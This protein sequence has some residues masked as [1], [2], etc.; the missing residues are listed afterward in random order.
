MTE[1][2]IQNISLYI[3]NFHFWG[4]GAAFLAAFLETILGLGLIFPGSSMILFLGAAAAYG[5]LDFNGVLI[6]SM[7]GAVL[8]DNINYYLGRNYAQKWIK[9]GFWF[10]KPNY[11]RKG[12]FY[13]Q[14]HGGE[15]VFLGRFIPTFK[16]VIPFVAGAFKMTRKEFIFWNI[17]GGLGWSLEWAGAGYLFA[18]SLTLA[19]LWLSRISFFFLWLFLIVALIMWWR[20]LV[21]QRKKQEQ[22]WHY[23][24]WKFA[25]KKI[26][27]NEWIRQK[28]KQYPHY[29]QIARQRFEE[30]SLIGLPLTW[31]VIISIV[32]WLLVV[33]GKKISE[34]SQVPFIDQVVI[35]LIQYIQS[36]AIIKYVW[37]ISFLG[38]SWLIVFLALLISIIW[39]IKNKKKYVFSFW[40]TLVGAE[41]TTHWLKNFIMRSRPLEAFYKEDS[42]SFPSG[43]ATL[44]MAFYGFLIYFLTKQTRDWKRKINYLWLGASLI[45]IVGF[46]RLYLNVHYFSDVIAGYVVGILWLLM[47]IIMINWLEK[48]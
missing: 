10:L 20:W 18:Q 15:S 7:T 8:G 32:T 36:V 30:K 35:Y 22:Y 21:I 14:R 37:I 23:P 11:F 46:S 6:A 4:Y 27:N 9:K 1:I 34:L 19:K 28:E 44:A 41:L 31:L 25:F 43:H 39:W 33:W 5:W 26:L 38:K 3:T 29:F 13:F 24:L 2:L 42:F 16:E 48:K 47:G 40:L 45:F 12:E 17:L